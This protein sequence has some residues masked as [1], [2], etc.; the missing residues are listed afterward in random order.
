[1]RST[2]Q[3]TVQVSQEHLDNAL[4]EYLKR[5]R[6]VPV[7]ADVTIKRTNGAVAKTSKLAKMLRGK[8]YAEDNLQKLTLEIS[9]GKE[10][11]KKLG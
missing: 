5:W 11:K 10:G 3:L 7:D 9:Q 4:I 1:M 2:K 8:N 6:F